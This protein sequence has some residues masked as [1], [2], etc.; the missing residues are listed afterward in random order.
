MIPI[1]VMDQKMSHVIKELE[2][3]RKRS[4]KLESDLESL[5]SDYEIKKVELSQF[6]EQKRELVQLSRVQVCL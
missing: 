2:V 5:A 1:S 4:S 3:E 6:N